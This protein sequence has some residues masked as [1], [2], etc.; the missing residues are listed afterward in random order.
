MIYGIG[1]DLVENDRIGK[2]IRK[3]GPKFLSRVFTGEEIDY[4][5]RH[6]QASLHY[7]ARFAVKESFLKAIGKGLGAGVKL[8][9]IEVVNDPGG[10]PEIR[11]SGGAR[12]FVERAGIRKI[13]LSITHTKNYAS[14][15][16]VLEKGWPDDWFADTI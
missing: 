1:I 13:H 5:G 16:V 10:K 6:A 7:G 9:E 11:L 8:A 2:I 3:W 12:A 4:C 15:A 14:A